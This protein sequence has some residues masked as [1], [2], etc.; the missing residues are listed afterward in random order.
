MFCYFLRFLSFKSLLLNIYTVFAG[1]LL[2]IKNDQGHISGYRVCIQRHVTS[3]DKKQSRVMLFYISSVIKILCEA[4]K[5]N[6]SAEN[7][8]NET[9]ERTFVEPKTRRRRHVQPGQNWT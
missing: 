5:K 4:V 1:F 2:Y 7:K 9:S 6:V 3:F 8:D